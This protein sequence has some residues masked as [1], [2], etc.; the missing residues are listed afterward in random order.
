VGGALRDYNRAKILGTRSFGKGSVQNILPLPNEGAIKLT[1]ARYYTPK[2]ISIQ[3]KGIEPDFNVEETADGNPFAEFMQRESDN[4][5]ALDNGSKPV[6][7]KTP[8]ER[9]KESEERLKRLEKLRAEGRKP[10]E[11]G[12]IAKDYQLQQAMNLIQGKP[13]ATVKAE[14]KKDDGKKDD[15]T[16]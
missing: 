7:A 13:V 12:D 15:A 11:Y 6:S 3:A 2:D 4:D 14:P 10:P 9:N 1:I 5:R 16:K 8:E